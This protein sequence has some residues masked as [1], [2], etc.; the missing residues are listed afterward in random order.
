MHGLVR[1]RGN[2]E[3]KKEAKQKKKCKKY[4]HINLKV[5]TTKFFQTL[6]A[7]AVVAALFTLRIWFCTRGKTVFLSRSLSSSHTVLITSSQGGGHGG[8]LLLLLLLPLASTS[9]RGN[10]QVKEQLF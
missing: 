7:V 10:L 4:T 6:Q 5:D 8:A 3:V 1:E 2:E 9:G